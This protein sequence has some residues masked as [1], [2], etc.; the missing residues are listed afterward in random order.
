MLLTVSIAAA[1]AAV[2]TVVRWFLERSSRRPTRHWN[3]V[4]EVVTVYNE[5]MAFGGKYLRGRALLAASAAVLGIA[6]AESRRARA[7]LGFGLVLGGG[8]SNLAERLFCG[9]VLD[10]LHFPKAPGRVGRLVFNLADFAIFFGALLS[11]GR[12]K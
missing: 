10:Y 7:P 1:V 3:G 2:C 5:A 6:L 8:L 11:L 4:V 12:R 9:R